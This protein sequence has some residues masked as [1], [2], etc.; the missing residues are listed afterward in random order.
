MVVLVDGGSGAGKTRLAT[1]LAAGMGAQ[2]V[3]L[4]MFYPGWDGLEAGSRH[5]HEAVLDPAVAAWRRWD[6]LAQAPA[7]WH[8]VDPARPLVVEGCGALSVVNRSLVSLAIWIELDEPTR[9]ARALARDGEAYA[10]HWERWAAQ[11]RAF[12]ARERPR[13]LADIVI[14]GALLGPEDPR[15]PAIARG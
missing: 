12:W 1:G 7:E 8:P 3:S 4:D 11:E 10:P 15:P 2:L 6:W 14:D 9:R 5:V 13:E